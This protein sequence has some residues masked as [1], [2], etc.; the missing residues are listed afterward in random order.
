MHWLQRGLMAVQ[1]MQLPALLKYP[2]TH[3]LQVDPVYPVEHETQLTPSLQ[4]MQR[5]LITVHVKHTLLFM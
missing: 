5:E 4:S 1:R 3:E 2:A